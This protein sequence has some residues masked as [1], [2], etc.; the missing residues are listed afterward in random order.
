VSLL[1]TTLLRAVL[2]YSRCQLLNCCTRSLVKDGL[3]DKVAAPGDRVLL[4]LG[5]HDSPGDVNIVDVMCRN[6]FQRFCNVPTTQT[7][8]VG[9]VSF[10]GLGALIPKSDDLSPHISLSVKT[11]PSSETIDA[12][13][14]RCSSGIVEHVVLTVPA[15]Q[16][17]LQGT[18]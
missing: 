1:L 4:L 18:H 14:V 17:M 8:M 7:T 12:I 6:P 13:H 11:M 5:I 9:E 10:S 2:A 15:L 16:D 3:Q